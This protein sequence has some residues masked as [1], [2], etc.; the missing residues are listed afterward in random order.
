MVF[1]AR[2][3][4]HWK[5]ILGQG[6][7]LCGLPV[8]I[9]DILTLRILLF[10]AEKVKYDQLCLWSKVAVLA[11]E[12]NNRIALSYLNK[13]DPDLSLYKQ[14]IKNLISTGLYWLLLKNSNVD[15]EWNFSDSEPTF[16]M[17]S[18]RV[19]DPYRIHFLR[20]RIQS[21]M[22]ETNTDP[23]TDPDPIQYGSRALMTKNF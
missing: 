20:I 4:V 14:K 15:P 3:F 11:I 18:D 9:N 17:V 13:M 16:Q 12:S 19:V 10:S 5:F 2:A 8:L 7:V 23:D 6:V 21:L 1:F 22:L